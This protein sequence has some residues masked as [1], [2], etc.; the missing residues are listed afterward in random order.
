VSR[1]EAVAALRSDLEAFDQWW[2]DN[3]H[4]PML[5][6]FDE[7]AANFHEWRIER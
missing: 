3:A 4:P 6:S 7:W 1:E 2:L 5:P